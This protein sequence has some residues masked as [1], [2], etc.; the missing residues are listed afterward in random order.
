M[1]NEAVQQNSG[2]DLACDGEQGDT[3]VIV[4]SLSISFPF[5]EVHDG[6][7]SE[8]LRD[9]LLLPYELEELMELLQQGPAAFLV[10]FGWDG[11]C[12]RG[13]AT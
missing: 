10:D 7:I 12:A 1:R 4:A 2:Q 3:T 13:F 6:R 5:V 11:V 8:V 9:S